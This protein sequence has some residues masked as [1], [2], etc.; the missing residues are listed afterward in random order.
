[1]CGSIPWVA[2]GME[3]C[4]SSREEFTHF[5]REGDLKLKKQLKEQRTCQ[6]KRIK[7]KTPKYVFLTTVRELFG[8][9]WTMYCTGIP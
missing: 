2:P 4:A 9:T 5:E 3:T 7:E 8:V 6:K 1:M